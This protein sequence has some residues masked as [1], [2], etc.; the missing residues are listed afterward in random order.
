VW[1]DRKIPPGKRFDEVIQEKLDAAKCVVVLW[2]KESVKSDWVKEEAEEGKRRNILVPVLIDSVTVPLGFRRIQTANLTDWHGQSPHAELD[3]LMEAVEAILGVAPSP[4]TPEPPELAKQLSQGIQ[5]L[6]DV[7]TREPL[8]GYKFIEDGDGKDRWRWEIRAEETDW[9]DLGKDWVS[10]KEQKPVGI[11]FHQVILPKNADI[12]FEAEMKE[13]GDGPQIDVVISDVAIQF[14]KGGIRWAKVGENLGYDK[15]INPEDKKTY[16]PPPRLAV[17][18]CFKFKVEKRGSGVSYF[19][20]DKKITSFSY[21]CRV[22]VLE[23][24]L[25]FYH[26]HNKVEFRNIRIRP[27]PTV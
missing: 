26:W 14:T 21:K 6:L 11:I 18:V 25:G 23:D 5:E 12:E 20:D 22:D 9:K 2:S 19:I 24:R 7:M 27:L 15:L 1:W 8:P 16:T 17:G 3:Q 10:G 13:S 4:N